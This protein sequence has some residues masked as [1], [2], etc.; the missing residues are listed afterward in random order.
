MAIFAA[1]DSAGNFFYPA[2]LIDKKSRF[3][4][5]ECTNIR[6]SGKFFHKIQSE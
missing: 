6:F 5:E 4:F 2:T 1:A 3:S